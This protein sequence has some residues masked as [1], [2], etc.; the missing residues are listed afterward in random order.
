MSLHANNPQSEKI[1]RYSPKPETPSKQPLHV[2]SHTIHATKFG[3]SV[4]STNTAN[5]LFASVKSSHRTR[6][7]RF[8]TP[9]IGSRVTNIKRIPHTS[10]FGPLIGSVGPCALTNPTHFILFQTQQWLR[11]ETSHPKITSHF[12]CFS[13]LRNRVL[14]NLT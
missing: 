7:L 2:R 9:P 3:A 11:R 13:T 12:L 6:L 10:I 4:K 14:C 5:T 8:V 1:K